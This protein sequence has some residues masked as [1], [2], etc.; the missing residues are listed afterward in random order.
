MIAEAEEK[1]APVID[2]TD[3][4][5]DD[6][7]MAEAEV[8]PE[9][10]VDMP[11]KQNGDTRLYQGTLKLLVPYP[12]DE[13]QPETLKKS[14]DEV[15]GLRI[16][17]EDIHIDNRHPLVNYVINLEKPTP[18]LKILKYKLQVK[19]IVDKGGTIEFTTTSS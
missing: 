8:E 12:F 19:N 11:D 13:V 2:M 7:V 10:V 14:L 16:L 5:N 9:S 1:M 3:K 6:T 17:S 18:I 4:Q 15:P